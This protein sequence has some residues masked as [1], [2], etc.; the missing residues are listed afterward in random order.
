MSSSVVAEAGRSM[1][2]WHAEGNSPDRLSGTGTT[3]RE[4]V[5]RQSS[6]IKSGEYS[7]KR[8]GM[9]DREEFKS[10]EEWMRRREPQ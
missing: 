9:E 4:R 5:G 7:L 8:T 3:S 6:G 1:T 10:S 2:P